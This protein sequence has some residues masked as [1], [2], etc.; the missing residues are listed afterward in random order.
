LALQVAA[1][2]EP[3]A[4]RRYPPHVSWRVSVQDVFG[5]TRLAEE[6][7]DWADV[8]LV[9]H[10]Y[11]LFAGIA[12]NSLLQLLDAVSVPVVTMLHTV[13][14]RPEPAIRQV[15]D[16]ICAKSSA[17]LVPGPR[18]EAVLR[19][20]YRTDMTAVVQVPH[21]IGTIAR[22]P[23]KSS[24][25]LLMGFGFLGPNKGVEH[26]LEAISHLVEHWPEVCYRFVGGQHPNEVRVSG[27]E[28]PDRLRRLAARLD[29]SDRV[30]FVCRY[31]SDVEL[32]RT[33]AAATVCVLPYTDIEQAVSGTLVRAIGAGRAV[34]A[35]PFRHA[36]EAADLGAVHL[37]QTCDPLGIAEAVALLLTDR[38][39]RQ[40]L[41][42]R[43]RAMASG[44][45]WPSVARQYEWVLRR[46]AGI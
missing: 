5:F 16:S 22:L 7:A 19:Q 6:L 41:E 2:D 32:S 26:V 17:I 20:V 18:S 40:R 8:V 33:L 43:A 39:Y 35:T 34:V 46:A 11:G 13:L 42:E 15:T 27:H 37:V 38:R 24:R 25:P 44:L 23:E 36:L 9:Q 45:A 21:G 3:G 4:R 12:G 28:Y 31:V 1:I 14:S 30:K 10:E 29:V